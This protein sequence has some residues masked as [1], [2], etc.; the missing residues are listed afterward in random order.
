[1]IYDVCLFVTLVSIHCYPRKTAIFSFNGSF[2]KIAD[3]RVLRKRM[4]F[5]LLK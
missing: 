3:I 4:S 5:S 1:M 2:I